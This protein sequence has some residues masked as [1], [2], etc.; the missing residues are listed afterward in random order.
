M[1]NEIT[2]LQYK[3]TKQT[4]R[5]K[6][7]KINLLNFNYLIMDS[8]EGNV[9]DGEIVLEHAREHCRIAA[10]E[11]AREDEIIGNDGAGAVYEG[12]AAVYME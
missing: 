9:I 5:N 3:T 8:L 6:Y 2:S 10:V 1:P 7:I 12:L 4:I 11:V